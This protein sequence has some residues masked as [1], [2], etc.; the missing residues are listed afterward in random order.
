[1]AFNSFMIKGWTITLVVVTLLL[2][3]TALYQTWIAFI[4]TSDVNS[5]L[6]RLSHAASC[7]A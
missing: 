4:L 3:G 5:G 2:K 7:L 6:E 1:M